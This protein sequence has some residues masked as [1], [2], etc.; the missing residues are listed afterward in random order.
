MYIFV[1]IIFVVMC[2]LACLH[3]YS[4][5]FKFCYNPT[6]RKNIKLANYLRALK[7]Q[8]SYYISN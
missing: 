3:T 7:I 2:F 6:K 1:Q 4:R 5:T 8:P